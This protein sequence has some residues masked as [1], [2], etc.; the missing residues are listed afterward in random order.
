MRARAGR[1]EGENT[2]ARTR[3]EELR[4][5]QLIS[6]DEHICQ[7][8]AEAEVP[9]GGGQCEGPGRGR[10]WWKQMSPAAAPGTRRLPMRDATPHR[11]RA[12]PRALL[13]GQLRHFGASC[14]HEVVA[15]LKI[16]Q[17]RLGEVPGVHGCEFMCV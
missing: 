17:V 13:P 12:S 5:A 15:Q 3:V 8:Q 9:A 2:R 10:G 16:R 14:R 11:A 4:G 1:E 6:E 7:G